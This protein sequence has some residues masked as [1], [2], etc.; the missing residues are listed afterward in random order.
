MEYKT[1]FNAMA[2]GTIAQNQ[3]MY[4]GE[5]GELL[6]GAFQQYAEGRAAPFY[7]CYDY[8]SPYQLANALD[9][10]LVRGEDFENP[11]ILH[12]FLREARYT[13]C[14]GEIV[15]EQGLSNDRRLPGLDLIQISYPDVESNAIVD[16]Y[17]GNFNPLSS[18][19]FELYDFEWPNG[20]SQTDFPSD[21]ITNDWECPFDP[22]DAKDSD[23]GITVGY[24]FCF[25]L[26]LV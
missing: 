15:L 16:K 4:L 8:D 25:G 11:L 17:V 18:T 22:D 1:T 13:G 2:D 5:I 24:C 20:N 14:S 21:T 19:R 9:K 6:T 7:T 3:P 26:F 12:R 10:A 23:Y